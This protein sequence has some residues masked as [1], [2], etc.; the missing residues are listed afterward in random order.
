MS[1]RDITGISYLITKRITDSLS[2][3]NRDISKLY[4]LLI[5]DIKRD[6]ARSIFTL[7]GY[8]TLEL[9]DRIGFDNLE[10]ETIYKHIKQLEKDLMPIR[11]K[12]IK[13]RFQ[14]TLKNLKQAHSLMINKKKKLEDLIKSLDKR[15]K[16]NQSLTISSYLVFQP[17]KLSL[18]LPM[19]GN[20]IDQAGLTENAIRDPKSIYYIE[21]LILNLVLERFQKDYNGSFRFEKQRLEDPI[22]GIDTRIESLVSINLDYDPEIVYLLLQDLES[23]LQGKGTA[24]QKSYAPLFSFLNKYLLGISI[25]QLPTKTDQLKKAINSISELL[26]P[27]GYELREKALFV[28]RA[29]RGIEKEIEEEH[30]KPFRDFVNH[31]LDDFIAKK[32]DIITAKGLEIK[33]FRKKLYTYTYAN[34]GIGLK[35]KGWVKKKDKKLVVDINKLNR[36]ERILIDYFEKILRSAK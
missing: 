31:I 12:E 26:N 3:T 11:D 24:S 20:L 13:K 7:R 27:L 2:Q 22:Q 29:V 15:N 1:K 30:Y 36:V 19:G 28:P 4:D 23:D 35:S 25:K 10:I 32:E 17:D 16:N 14:E 34:K 8:Y 9:D 5:K 33:K 6:L 18:Y 21:Q